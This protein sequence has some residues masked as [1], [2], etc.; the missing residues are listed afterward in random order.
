MPRH[1][2]TAMAHL[3]QSELNTVPIVDHEAI[4]SLDAAIWTWHAT[5]CGVQNHLRLVKLAF[6][7]IKHYYGPSR[8]HSFL[9]LRPLNFGFLEITESQAFQV[10]F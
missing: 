9:R 10:H 1:H 2:S 6:V 8:M 4:R 3:D 5:W 7:R